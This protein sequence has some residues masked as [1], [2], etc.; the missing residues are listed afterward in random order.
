V[1]RSSLSLLIGIFISLVLFWLMQTMIT[2]NQQPMKISQSLQMT[3]FI[4]LKKLEK[5]VEKKRKLPEEQPAP[6]PPPSAAPEKPTE[7]QALPEM[8]IPDLAMPEPEV[9]TNS[10][11]QLAEA[12]KPLPQVIEAPKIRSTQK[13]VVKKKI[14]KK[15]KKSPKKVKKKIKPTPKKTRKK[16]KPIKKVKKKTKLKK[17]SK[18]T[19]RTKKDRKKSK[20]A[21][22][23][24]KKSKSK[25]T[26][27]DRKKSKRIQKNKKK[28]KS[29][30][31]RRDEMMAELRAIKNS[32]KKVK[33][34]KRKK[35]KSAAKKK[36]KNQR[37][38]SKSNASKGVKGGNSAAKVLS[39]ARPK[40]P[41]RAR[42]NGQQGWVR[43][44]FVVTPN[45]RVSG[46]TV[47]GSKPSGVFNSAA[48]SAIRRFRF[49]PKKVN[50]RAVSQR[51]TQTIHFKL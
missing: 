23:D 29:K 30:R 15:V 13:A 20:Q 45:G 39:R 4:K 44:R 49:K 47:V 51:M 26:K 32:M 5:K 10:D 36:A 6:P 7:A 21:K 37:K 33:Q 31:S 16:S 40:Y 14:K 25:R 9:L 12:P 28:S 35:S 8:A 38:N 17:V 1:K 34:I 18:K 41:R 50:G 19:K 46:A 22:K 24:R 3:E 48:L 42:R 2:N 43:V 11:V 27:K